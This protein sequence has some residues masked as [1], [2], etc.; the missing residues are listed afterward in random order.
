MSRR[1]KATIKSDTINRMTALGNYKQEYDDLINLYVDSV[2]QYHKQMSVWE[3]H[4][5]PITEEYTNKAGATNARK[6]PILTVIDGYRKDIITLSD[7]LMLNPKADSVILEQSS[8][9]ASPFGKFMAENG[10]MLHV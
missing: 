2:Y 10:G 1:S 9:S 4:G 8:N 3:K 5:S 7:K 6:V